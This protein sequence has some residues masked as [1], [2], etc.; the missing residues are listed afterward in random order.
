LKK[1]YYYSR[2]SL[3]TGQPS[4]QNGMYGLHHGIHHFNSFNDI[5][6]LP[7]ILKKKNIRTGRKN[8]YNLF[9][10]NFIVFHKFSN[11]PLSLFH[12][13]KMRLLKDVVIRSFAIGK[14]ENCT[15]IW[16]CC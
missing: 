14:R 16:N 6:S 13:I 10:S 8:Q 11:K 1:L 2:A 12:I 7:K 5:Q 15:I 3:L 4:H 9:L